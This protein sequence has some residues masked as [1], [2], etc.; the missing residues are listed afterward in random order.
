MWC[1]WL[2]D[3]LQHKIFYNKN[4]AFNGKLKKEKLHENWQKQRIKNNSY[5][6]GTAVLGNL[7]DLNLLN[8]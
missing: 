2:S 7:L 4:T 3:W 1:V 8:S 5:S 6:Y